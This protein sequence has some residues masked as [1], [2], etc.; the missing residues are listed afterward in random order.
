MLRSF[1]FL[2]PPQLGVFLLLVSGVLLSREARAQAG[3]PNPTVRVSGTVSAAGTRESIPGATVVVQ[4]TRRGVAA[5][6]AYAMDASKVR[7]VVDSDL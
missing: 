1:R 5:D 6:A 7:V 4:R 3:A 2:F